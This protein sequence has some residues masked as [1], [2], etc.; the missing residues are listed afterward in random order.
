YD[1]SGNG[2]AGTLVNMNTTGNATSGWADGRFGNALQFDGVND[3]VDAGNGASLNN[4]FGSE[5]FTLEAWVYPKDWVNYR[6]IINKR[7]SNYYSAS[8]GGLFAD[9]SGIKFIIGTG[10]DAETSTI[11]NYKPTLNNWHHIAGTARRINSTHT[12]MT[13]YVDG[14]IRGSAL[15]TIDPQ[16]NNNATTIGAV[17]A[18]SRSFN[19]TIDEVRVWSK[20]F[21]PDETVAMKQ[22][23]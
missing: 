9:T 12:N 23:I 17:Y 6:G 16:T 10:N 2:N 21:S 11:I 20:A 1:A 3:Y 7:S 18:N 4:V 13:L 19:G 8:P 22:I 15:T 14:V 5:I